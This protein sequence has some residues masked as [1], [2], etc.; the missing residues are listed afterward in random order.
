MR[1][2][3]KPLM[4]IGLLTGCTQAAEPPVWYGPATL[5]TVT[6]GIRDDFL[7]QFTNTNNWPA[8]Y[9]KTTVFK[10]FIETL[11]GEKYSDAQLKKLATFSRE[12]GLKCAFEI[13]A[14]RWTSGLY[15]EGSGKKYAAQE[16]KA[17]QRWVDAGG[18]VDYLSTDHAVMW[19]IGLCFQGARPMVDYVADPDWRKVM[20]EVADSLATIHLAFPD[21]KIGMIE[22]LGYFSVGNQYTTTDP[23][24]IYPIDFEEFLRTAQRR[25]G[26]RG[27]ELDHFHI[28]FSYQDCRYDG[29]KE[30]RLDFG[31]I[32]AAEKTVKSLGIDC[33]II[34]NAFDDFSYT[35]VNIVQEKERAQNAAER[36]A[37]AVKNT[38]EYFDGYVAGGGEPDTW[39]FQ[40]WQPYPDVTGPELDRNTDMGVTR[41]L[42]NKLNKK[43]EDNG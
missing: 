9:G 22:S 36:S 16:I 4:L 24:C 13:G 1:H 12:A 25:L 41:L 27:V 8:V 19:N 42:I 2:F 30:K 21:A 15:G 10:Q 31:R 18:T 40:R 33:G 6:R 7:E 34:I 5:N 37:S 11:G 14:L 23:Q 39:I 28:D 35:G 38:L 17:L 43:D 32:L 26:E 20:D 3:L 29:R